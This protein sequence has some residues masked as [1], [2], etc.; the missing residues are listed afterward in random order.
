MRAAFITGYGDNAVV[1]HGEVPDAVAG[2]GEALIEVRAAG[3]NPVEVYMRQGAFHAAFPF[4]FP[5]VMGFDISGV[6]R[7]APDGG[8]FRVGDEVYA[9]LP[10]PRGAYAE[11]AAVP[12]A[13]LAPK[14]RTLS[15]AEAASLPTVA[16]TTWQ[17]FLERA[18]LKAGEHVLIQAGAGG[19]G[20]FAIQLAKHLGAKVTATASAANQGWMAEL[21]AD[22][23]IDYA[24]EPFEAAGPFDVV[25]DGVCGPLVER[26]IQSL[27]PGGRYVGIVRVADAQS[28][29]E[30]GFP[31]AVATGA[32]AGVQPFIEQAKAKGGEFHGPLTRSDGAQL[33]EIGAIIDTGAIRATVSQVYGLADLAA[34]YDALATGRTRG[35]LVIAL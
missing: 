9:R 18:R 17:S 33:A 5:Q 30:I 34:A 4:T 26:G 13:L 6:V 3:V 12:V 8:P 28:Y 32:A 22:R 19:V 25:Y 1:S 21:G 14:P 27:K 11:L 16:L 23:T 31:D 35:K 2:A 15:H 20:S 7:A 29:R 24:T 10:N